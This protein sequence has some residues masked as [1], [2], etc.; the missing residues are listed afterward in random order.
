LENTFSSDSFSKEKA[1]GAILEDGGVALG[2][3][4][5]SIFKVAQDYDTGFGAKWVAIFVVLDNEDTHRWKGFA[6]ATGTAKL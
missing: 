4:I 1:K 5:D 6:N 2:F 3:V